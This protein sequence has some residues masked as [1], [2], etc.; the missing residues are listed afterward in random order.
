MCRKPAGRRAIRYANRQ[1]VFR[2][3]MINGQ[4]VLAIVPARGGSK[5]VPRKNL[6]PV[7]GKPLIAWTIEAAKHSRYIDKLVISSEDAEIISVAK[8]LGCDAPFVRPAA[9]ARDD[10]PGIDPV[11]HALSILPGY[12]WVV[13]LQPTSPLRTANDIDECLE[14]CIRAS[15]PSCVSVTEAAESPFWMYSLGE[16]SELLPVLTGQY[17]STRRQ[18]LPLVFVLNGAV[19][20]A[21]SEWL[22][23]HRT[24]V[25]SE[26]LAFQMPADRSL[27]VDTALDLKVF[28]LMSKNDDGGA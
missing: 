21:R 26:T 12:W 1:Q 10:T 11:L 7:G 28:E 18:D 23:R 24:F 4:S 14:T 6:H 19:Y 20:V 9:L 13:L 27:D 2:Y 15:A 22:A 25:S 17:G 8:A 16:H 3:Q 5:G